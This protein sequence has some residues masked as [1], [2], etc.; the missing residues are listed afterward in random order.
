VCPT[1]H[2]THTHRNELCHDIAVI[3]C[4]CWGP[5]VCVCCAALFWIP[6]CK[7]MSYITHTNHSSQKWGWIHFTRMNALWHTWEW[8]MSH[9]QMR[10]IW[11]SHTA[12]EWVTYEWVRS[13]T[14]ESCHTYKSVISSLRAFFSIICRC[15][16]EVTACSTVCCSVL[17]S[18]AAVCCSL[19]QSVAFGCSLLQSVAVCC[20]LLQSVAV[21]CSLL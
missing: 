1:T 12:Y 14:N 7:W 20:S 16:Q 21:C 10:H 11:M 2:T 5:P 4:M 15:S 19:L 17:Q 9:I 13:H 8:V 6:V 3:V 18:V